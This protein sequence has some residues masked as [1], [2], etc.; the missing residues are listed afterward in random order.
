MANGCD[1]A[2]AAPKRAGAQRNDAY[3]V[4]I[5]IMVVI[6]KAR[7]LISEVVSLRVGSTLPL[8]CCIDEMVEIYA[9]Y[10]LIARG[11]LQQLEEG[12]GRMGVRL[13][14]IVDIEQGY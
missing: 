12:N 11:E 9:G 7:P 5:E 8:D 4:P 1:V 3:G 14:E 10:R 13:T 6:G 2:E